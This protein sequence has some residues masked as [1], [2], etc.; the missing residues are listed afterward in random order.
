[1][2]GRWVS[3][4]SVYY[5]LG[6]QRAPPRPVC[7]LVSSESHRRKHSARAGVRTSTCAR[8]GRGPSPPAPPTGSWRWRPLPPRARPRPPRRRRPWRAG[9]AGV[10]TA[11]R[12]RS[13]R[14]RPA[15]HPSR[16]RRAR[17][18][19]RW[20]LPAPVHARG[21]ATA[22]W[23]AGGRARR[24]EPGRPG[25]ACLTAAWRA[26]EGGGEGAAA[27]AEVCGAAAA[28][29]AATGQVGARQASLH[30]IDLWRCPA[31]PSFPLPLPLRVELG[32][33]SSPSLSL[34]LSLSRRGRL[35]A[36]VAPRTALRSVGRRHGPCGGVPVRP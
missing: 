33:R 24:G 15:G 2:S 16:P 27:T 13:V 23:R 7:F 34:S 19:C 17:A 35:A 28:N 6:Q 12:R 22:A 20:P 3:P 18:G 21:R 29:G 14:G 25:A 31:S 10:A 5:L 4:L 9:R 26:G 1:M 32:R 36:A 8:G 11:A 30:S